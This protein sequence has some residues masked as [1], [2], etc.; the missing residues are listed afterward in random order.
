VIGYCR[1]SSRKQK[2]D[3]EKQISHVRNYMIAKAYQFEIIK[4]IRSGMNYNNKGLNQI[5]DL[6]TNSE[7]EKIVILYKD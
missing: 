1:V 7:K 3:L 5:L 6:I 4:D 2:D